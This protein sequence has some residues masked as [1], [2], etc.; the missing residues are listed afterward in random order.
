M[1]SAKHMNRRVLLSA[2]AVLAAGLLPAAANAQS[3]WPG[4]RPIKIIE[5]SA[6]G[7]SG[8]V[9]A[10]LLAGKLSQR[11]GQSV[12]VE[13]KTGAGGSLGTDAVA[14]SAPDG[15]TL[16]MDT[17]AIATN[18]A[19]GKKLPYDPLQ[20]FV[21]IGQI[22]VTPLLVAVPAESPIKTLGDLVD[23]ARARP[24]D[25]VRYGSS[26]VGSMSHIGMA[27]LASV[28]NVQMMHVP[29][30]GL[31]LSTSDLLGGQLQATL[32]SFAT[33]QGLLESGKLRAIAISS[34]TRS[35]FLPNVPTSA[36]AGFPGFQIDYWW[37][38]TGPAGMPPGIVERLNRELNAVLAEPDV[39]A[40]LARA[41]AV[42]TPGTPQ[43]FDRFNAS[44]VRRW[45]K[46]IREAGIVLE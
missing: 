18:S 19:S 6:P 39:R 10:R 14:K 33:N 4:Q 44:E 45:R 23:L 41:A 3:A 1:Q 13:N 24:N 25:S 26:G 22:G 12:V 40:F 29:Y 15:Y 34:A 7:G 32:T 28:A 2:S 27:L 5:V 9:M 16:L 8:D 20:D 17:S 30:K 36:E 46:V 11:L 21:R 38:L 42:P 35:P 37:G 31:S 43:E